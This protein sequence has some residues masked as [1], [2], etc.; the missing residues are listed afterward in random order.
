MLGGSLELDVSPA[1]ESLSFRQHVNVQPHRRN[2]REKAKHGVRVQKATHCGFW[3]RSC[4]CCTLSCSDQYDDALS[5][6]NQRDFVDKRRIANH[7][8][9][10]KAT[11]IKADADLT[12]KRIYSFVLEKPTVLAS[13]LDKVEQLRIKKLPPLRLEATTPMCTKS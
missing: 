13:L 7:T 2:V 4:S 1:S 6:G 5:D 3:P 8:R 10:D 11:T 9:V 12:G